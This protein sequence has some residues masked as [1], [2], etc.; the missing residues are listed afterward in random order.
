MRLIETRDDLALV[1]SDVRMP[2]MSG[3]E[4]MQAMRARR[5][6]L[7]VILVTGD[8]KSIDKVISSHAIAVLKP[9]DFGILECV[10][11]DALD[12]AHDA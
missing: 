3:I 2:G 6:A 1:L 11:A 4:L 8:P 12:K 5:P 7:K 9:Y 10:V